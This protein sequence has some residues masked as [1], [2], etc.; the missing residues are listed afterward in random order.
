MPLDPRTPVLVGAGQLKRRPDDVA[1]ASDP[2]AMM[3]DVARLAEADTGATGVLD[4]VDSVRVVDI[5]SWH[6]GDPAAEVARRL[7]ISPRQTVRTTTGGNSP[8]SLVSHTARAVQAGELDVALLVGAE[9]VYSR[10]RA[11]RTEVRF[12]WP[13]DTPGEPDLVL[14]DDRPG[15]HDAEVAR[16]IVMPV[17]VYPMFENALR[18][19]AGESVDEHQVKISELWARF[20][21]VA[22]TNPY[23]WNPGPYT[24]EQIRTVTPDNRLIGFP[25]PKL[26]NSNIDVDMAAGVLLCSVEAARSLGIP[27]DRWVFPHSGTDATD[28]YFISNRADLHSSPAIRIAG[29]RAL[30]LAGVQAGDLGPVDLYSCFPAAVQISAAE[31]GLGLERDLTVTGGLCFAG[32]PANNY[33]M[34]AIATMVGRLRDEPGAVGLCTAL[35]WYVTKH[36]FGVYSTTPPENGFR[37]EKP[38]D[39]VDAQPSREVATEH[40]GDVTVETY[41]VMHERDGSPSHAIVACLLPDGRRAWGTSTEPAVLK[42]MTTEEVC[43]RPGRLAADGTVELTA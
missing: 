31:L 26:M 35:G 13:A 38:Q 34:H 27:E 30:E 33:V 42:A 18:A 2:A 14:G 11:R 3:A 36:A 23:A 39:E 41:T 40:T 16:G 12:D 25:Y 6:Y 15:N 7:G 10:W 1:G 21:Q 5:V 28:H 8:Q 43:G 4:R 22:T 19:A 29:A 20:S 32:G 9:A 17:Q 24:A 37:W